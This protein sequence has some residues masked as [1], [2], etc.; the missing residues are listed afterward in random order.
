MQYQLI[1][2]VRWY[3]LTGLLRS[4]R[5]EDHRRRTGLRVERS[6]SPGRFA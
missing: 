4:L 1:R 5:M 2:V 3:V 6:G